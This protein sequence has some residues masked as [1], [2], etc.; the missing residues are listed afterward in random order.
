M[1]VWKNVER[2]GLVG[3]LSEIFESQAGVEFIMKNLVIS[4]IKFII[5]K[6]LK[7]KFDKFKKI[8]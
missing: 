2:Y 7:S 8:N 1:E 3:R 5:L 4:C 6:G